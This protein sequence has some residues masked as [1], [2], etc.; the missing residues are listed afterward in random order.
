MQV[1]PVF[2]PNLIGQNKL[3]YL[4]LRLSAKKNDINTDGKFFA[5][6]ELDFFEF[7]SNLLLEYDR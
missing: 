3:E 4:K 5:S 7:S 2:Y 1:Y 6:L